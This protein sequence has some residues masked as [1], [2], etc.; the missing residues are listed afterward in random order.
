MSILPFLLENCS[1]SD[2]IRKFDKPYEANL[3]VRLE[4]YLG[5]GGVFI[6]VGAHIGNHSITLVQRTD[7]ATAVAFEP[8]PKTFQALAGNVAS[9]GLSERIAIHNV[10][11]GAADGT[12]TLSIVDARDM[13]TMSLLGPKEGLERH[14]VK[15]RP[16]DSLLPKLGDRQVKLIKIDTEGYESEVVKGAVELIKTHKPA[17]CAET[18]SVEEFN[19]LASLLAEL[20]YQPQVIYNATPTVIWHHIEGANQLDPDRN[21]TFRYAIAMAVRTNNLATQLRVA[22]SKNESAQNS[23]VLENY[24]AN[25]AKRLANA[26]KQ[27]AEPV[28]I[29]PDPGTP[30]AAETK[31]PNLFVIR[32]QRS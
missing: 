18:A 23:K 4:S 32:M 31:P 22:L 5:D 15:I 3:L 14:E 11:V 2:H 27:P 12:G 13:G 10:A 16:L 26:P 6:D 24:L 29:A 1:V 17:I 20:C 7:G 8:S 25:Q 28:E 19:Q 30:K 9:L 21:E